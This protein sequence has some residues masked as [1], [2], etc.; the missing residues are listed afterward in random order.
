MKE[1]HIHLQY[2]EDKKHKT[3]CLRKV[4]YRNEEGRI[5]Q[6]ITNNREITA[7]E[8]ALI[9]KYRQSIELIF[10]KLKQIFQLHFFYSESE[11]GIKAQD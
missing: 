11:N 6:F 2:K 1:E 8:V 9:Y 3:L 4:T 7:E 10:K 5:Y